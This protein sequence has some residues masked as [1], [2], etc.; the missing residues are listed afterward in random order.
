LVFAIVGGTGSFFGPIV[1]V[2]VLTAVKEA[3]RGFNEFLP[4][5]YGGILI[6]V[7]LF[8]P[9]G[10]IALPRRVSGWVQKLRRKRNIRDITA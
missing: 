8:Q 4:F 1:G 5:I 10:L 6:I 7:V 2:S 9:G 3:L